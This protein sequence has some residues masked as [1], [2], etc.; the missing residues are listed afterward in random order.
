MFALTSDALV[1]SLILNS[2]WSVAFAIYNLKH[3][4]EASD[5]YGSMDM[6]RILDEVRNEPWLSNA[7]FESERFPTLHHQN[8]ARTRSKPAQP[9]DRA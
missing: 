9:G 8:P 2:T 3:E 7:E 4:A 6:S 1:N 5:N